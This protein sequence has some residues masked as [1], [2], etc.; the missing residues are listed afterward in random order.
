MEPTSS[1]L[2][3]VCEEREGARGLRGGE[4]REARSDVA[5]RLAVVVGQLEGTAL[6]EVQPTA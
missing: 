1:R 4:Q 5:L 2:P 6:V 3:P